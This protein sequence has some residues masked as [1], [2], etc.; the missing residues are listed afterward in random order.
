[1]VVHHLHNL[2]RNS[3]CANLLS[4]LIREQD[5][6]DQHY[7]LKTGASCRFKV[8]NYN[9][10]KIYLLV[11]TLTWKDWVSAKCANLL[12]KKI[13]EDVTSQGPWRK[14]IRKTDKQKIS[15][16]SLFDSER[17]VRTSSGISDTGLTATMARV[18]L[19]VKENEKGMLHS[20]TQVLNSDNTNVNH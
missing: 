6:Q 9:K 8:N 18:T 13:Y 15:H 3:N 14:L 2:W 12:A 5:L 11:N 20:P 7:V 17:T 4:V 19:R 10:V 1:M 16:W